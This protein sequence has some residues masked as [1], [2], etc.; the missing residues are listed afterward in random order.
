[1]KKLIRIMLLLAAVIAFTGT[2]SAQQRKGNGRM[3]REQFAEKQARHIAVELNLSPEDTEKFITTYKEC[4]KETWASRPP[5]ADRRKQ[6]LTDAQTDSL[7]RARFDHSQKL[8]DIR[9]KYY[10]EYCKFL[11]PTQI[12]RVY[13]I[14]NR[15]MNKFFDRAGKKKTNDKKTA[16]KRRNSEN[17]KS[18]EKNKSQNS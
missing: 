1:M 11:T 13:D 15:M 4:Q 8:L 2:A 5:R 17:K 7:L 16:T 14:E 10:E 12:K 9:K 6:E 3:N 18:T